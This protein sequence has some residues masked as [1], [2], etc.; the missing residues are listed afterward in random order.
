MYLMR[1]LVE[2]CLA[3]VGAGQQD[4]FRRKVFNVTTTADSIG[5]LYRSASLISTSRCA[6]VTLEA[7]KLIR[8]SILNFYMLHMQAAHNRGPLDE[9]LV[10][11]R[12]SEQLKS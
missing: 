10:L 7:T 12:Q 4:D 3:G 6:A 11:L 9:V 8:A 2:T 5:S 1:G